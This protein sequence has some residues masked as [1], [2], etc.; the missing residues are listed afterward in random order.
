MLKDAVLVGSVVPLVGF[1][2][3]VVVLEGR[4]VVL[5]VGSDVLLVAITEVMYFWWVPGALPSSK[6]GLPM[7]KTLF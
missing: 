1:P 3:H 4:F 2:E 6:D 5:A 7:T